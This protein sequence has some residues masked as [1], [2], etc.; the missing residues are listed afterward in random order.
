MAKTLSV[1]RAG[2]ARIESWDDKNLCVNSEDMVELIEKE[3]E[4]ERPKRDYAGEFA[5][6]ITIAVE[7][8]GDMEVNHENA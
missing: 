4:K 1:T 7:L 2:L 8:L 5:A 6:R 3:V